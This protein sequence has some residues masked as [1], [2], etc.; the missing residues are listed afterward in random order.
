LGASHISAGNCFGRRG[1]CDRSTVVR[2]VSVDGLLQLAPAL[3]FAGGRSVF[4][5]DGTGCAGKL[6]RERVEDGRR[7]IVHPGFAPVLVIPHQGGENFA[8]GCN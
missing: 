7:S 2:D 1:W 6:Y 3:D 4:G 5:R 8:V